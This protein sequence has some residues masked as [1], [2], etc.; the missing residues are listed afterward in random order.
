MATTQLPTFLTSDFNSVSSKS[1]LLAPKM[2][3]PMFEEVLQEGATELM[4]ALEA[5]EL[6]REVVPVP[7][8]RPLRPEWRPALLTAMLEMASGVEQWMLDD[9]EDVAKS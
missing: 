1:F 6:T 2:V 7:L 5:T 4:T 9:V 3:F 8:P